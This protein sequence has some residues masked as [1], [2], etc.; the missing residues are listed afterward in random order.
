[1]SIEDNHGIR[2][3]FVLNANPDK[4]FGG[5][6]GVVRNIRKYIKSDVFY[7]R[8]S[9]FLSF[10]YPFL[11]ALKIIIRNYDVVNIHD[12]QGYGYMLLPDF[13]RKKTIYTCHGLWE[14]YYDI[15]KPKG[16]FQKIKA[17]VAKKMQKRIIKKANHI[18]AVS[19]YIKNEISSRFKIEK[20]KITVIHNGVD[21]EKFH[22][23]KLK[24]K[25]KN[26]IWVGKDPVRK[27]LDKAVEYADRHDMNL[28]VVGLEGVSTN[29]IT[30]LGNVSDT[31]LVN[32]YNTAS[33]LLFFTKAE[34]HPLVPLEAMACGL[35][36]IA[37][38][39]SNIEIVPL[40]KDGL[41]KIRG[42]YAR[43]II[44]KYDWKEQSKKHLIVIEKIFN[45]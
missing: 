17:E 16:L 37:S 3:C 25:K 43:K 42:K 28:I 32:L 13:L 2:I 10:L 35:D 26:A 8:G 20:S 15:T 27:G 9:G 38:K 7:G 29:K 36:V 33:I 24:R 31:E 23:M 22:N 40:S 39:E 14:I 18:I 30:Y 4:I 45:K 34:A 21:T 1:M 41:Y 12:T 6:P 5:T 11:T 19:E 44:E